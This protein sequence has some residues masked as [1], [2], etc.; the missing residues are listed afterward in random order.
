VKNE[1]GI[2]VQARLSSTRFPKKIIQPLWGDYTCLDYLLK[3]LKT[4]K[5]KN[6]IIIATTT[7]PVDDLLI[8]ELERHKD[9]IFIYRG[10]ENNVLSRT[11]EAAE[12][13]DIDTI[14][15]ITSDCVFADPSLIDYMFLIFAHHGYHYLSNV[16]TRSFPVGFD[17]QIYKTAVLK[18]LL[19]QSINEEHKTHSGWN[20][21]NYSRDLQA[22]LGDLKIGNYP[23]L[24]EYFKPDWRI[25][26]DYKEDLE[27][28]KVIA[29]NVSFESRYTEIMDFLMKKPKF[30][31]I[32]KNCTR[33]TPGVN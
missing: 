2:I 8:K 31:E 12:F 23:A 24:F 18:S 32:N 33:K 30:L 6:K 15:D 29:N 17:I 9:D 3:R 20:I 13:F 7:N 21:V 14:I 22:M 16:M 28:L 5:H 26:L 11:A 4:V 19:K 27:L 1:I 10:S 25:V